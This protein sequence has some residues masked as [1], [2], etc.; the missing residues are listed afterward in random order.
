[1]VGAA[2]LDTLAYYRSEHADVMDRIGRIEIS[3]GGT[4]LN[5]ALRRGPDRV[6]GYRRI[7]LPL[8]AWLVQGGLRGLV[9]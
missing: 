7:C 3:L 9:R 2:H 4:G 6:Q 5:V 1:M 8:R